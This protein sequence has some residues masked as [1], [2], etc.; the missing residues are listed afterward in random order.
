MMESGEGPLGL[1]KEG[2]RE[3]RGGMEDM[4]RERTPTSV[5][6]DTPQGHA[7]RFHFIQCVELSILLITARTPRRLDEPEPRLH[8]PRPSD[9]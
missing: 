8:E 2:G 3:E 1:G 4:H 9:V 7:E 6:F 5:L